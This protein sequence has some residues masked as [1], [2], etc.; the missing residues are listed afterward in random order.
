MLLN[1][2]GKNILQN[3]RRLKESVWGNPRGG[4]Y[5]P[6]TLLEPSVF[7]GTPKMKSLVKRFLMCLFAKRIISSTTLIKLF[8]S[9]PWLRGA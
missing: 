3:F 6:S 5:E 4:C 8:K 9:I 2:N 7:L 1:R